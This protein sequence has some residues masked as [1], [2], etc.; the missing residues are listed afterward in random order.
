MTV[1]YTRAQVERIAKYPV[2]VICFDSEKGAQ[3]RALRLARELEVF[4]GETSNVRLSGKDAATSPKAETR[5]LQ[6]M[7]S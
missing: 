7:L 5:E 2:R 6:R 4:P 1:S 3:D